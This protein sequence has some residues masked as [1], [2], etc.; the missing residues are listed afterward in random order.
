M[1]V[2]L[3]VKRKTKETTIEYIDE[4]CDPIDW[5][6]LGEAMVPGFLAWLEAKEKQ[7]A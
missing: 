4:P 1:K 6:G 3:T 5:E 2:K 7:T